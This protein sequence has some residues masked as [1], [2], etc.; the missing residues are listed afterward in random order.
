LAKITF[1]LLFTN[2]F[3]SFSLPSSKETISPPIPRSVDS[4]LVKATFP[5]NATNARK[6]A[7]NAT[8][9][10]DDMDKKRKDGNGALLALR[11]FRALS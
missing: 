8:D 1:S 11:T 9:A 6:Y 3:P 4:G 2:Y 7:T 5:S 10:A